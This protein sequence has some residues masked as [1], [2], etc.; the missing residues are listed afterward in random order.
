MVLGIV[1]DWRESEGR[2]ELCLTVPSTRPSGV[3]Y[4]RDREIVVPVPASDA[5]AL[6]E[7]LGGRIAA[8]ALPVVQRG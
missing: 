7:F 8:T 6:E 1:K 3:A 2:L 5:P 4:G